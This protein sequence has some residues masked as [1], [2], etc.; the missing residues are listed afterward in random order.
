MQIHI[1]MSHTFLLNL[2]TSDIDSAKPCQYNFGRFLL[3][4]IKYTSRGWLVITILVLRQ[5]LPDYICINLTPTSALKFA[6]EKGVLEGSL[7]NSTSFNIIIP[8]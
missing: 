6:L 1:F 3:F 2:F 8:D 5:D 4:E 7:L